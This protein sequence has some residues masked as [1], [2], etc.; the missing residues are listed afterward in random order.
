MLP[1]D[2]VHVNRLVGGIVDEREESRGDPGAR[3]R[4]A[5]L[6]HVN[7]RKETRTPPACGVR[8]SSVISGTRC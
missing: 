7:V 8:D 1:A 2:A 5:P 4:A 3:G 6:F